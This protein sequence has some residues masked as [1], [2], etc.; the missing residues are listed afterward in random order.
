MDTDVL[1]LEKKCNECFTFLKLSLVLC[2]TIFIEIFSIMHY[3]YNEMQLCMI[4][5]K[6]SKHTI[7][8]KSIADL[9]QRSQCNSLCDDTRI[10]CTFKL[11]K[12]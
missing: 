1:F 10:T 3:N 5:T 6:T 11:D 2:E 7:I 9:K 4:C 8:T 12:F